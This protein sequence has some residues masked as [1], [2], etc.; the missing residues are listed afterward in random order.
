MKNLCLLLVFSVSF[1]SFSQK[2]EGYFQYTANVQPTDTSAE[3]L[4][5]VSMMI[6]SKMEIYFA[7]DLAR[8]DFKMGQMFTTSIRIDRKAQRAISLS[9]SKAG[10]F[11]AILP[12]DALNENT[13]K[14]DTNAVL[15]LFDEEKTILGY[16]CKKAIL[17][18]GGK[19]TTYWYTNEIA[20]SSQ[21]FPILD[22]NVPGFPMEFSSIEEGVLMS[23]K[24]SNIIFG[25]ENH[26][27]IFSTVIPDEFQMT[28]Q[29]N[30]Q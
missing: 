27:V 1:L 4:Q 29:A 13:P 6:G 15:N 9:S 16:K 7:K 2:E 30:E 12:M 8:L 5:R 10:D 14:I 19:S 24:A 11:G 17:I 25:L 3:T 28:P 23:Y 22:P 20:I 21:D 18:I 26:D